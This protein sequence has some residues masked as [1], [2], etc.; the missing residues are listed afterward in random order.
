MNILEGVLLGKST[1]Y[2]RKWGKQKEVIRKYKYDFDNDKFPN[3][4]KSEVTKL[5]GKRLGCFCKPA[6]CH[7]DILADYLNSL[8]D[9]N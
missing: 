4:S 7:G 5:A 3:K 9:G 8:D 2:V 6:A 1:Q